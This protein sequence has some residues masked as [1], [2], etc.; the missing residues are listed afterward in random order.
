MSNENEEVKMEEN[1]ENT[2]SEASELTQ[3]QA[4]AAKAED[5][6]TVELL[7]LQAKL[8]DAQDDVLRAKAEVQNMMK[9]CQADVQRA[10]D[11]AL[12]R[13]ARDLVQVIEPLEKS[14]KFMD[15][16]NEAVKPLLEGVEQ[17]LAI[18]TKVLNQNGIKEIAPKEGEDAF[19]PIYHNAIQ[20]L[21][22]PNVPA[23][24]V[25]NVVQKGYTLNGRTIKAA[26]VIVSKGPSAPIDTQ[27]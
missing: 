9:R 7:E 18:F 14:V 19:D 4:D 16:K 1:V 10:K 13:F 5:V 26:M 17:T 23:N 27:A 21:E 22:V 2:S 6:A 20:M 12:D 8:K 25:I 3:E 24:R 11:N 15:R